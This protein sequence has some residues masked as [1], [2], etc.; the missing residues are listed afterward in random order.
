MNWSG[1]VTAGGNISSTDEE[2][3]LGQVKISSL[4][5]SGTSDMFQFTSPT[6][7]PYLDIGT[8]GA[9]NLNGGDGTN[10]DMHPVDM[11]VNLSG[12]TPIHMVVYI[13]N[14]QLAFFANRDNSGTPR[15]VAGVLQAQQ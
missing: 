15:I 9:V 8:G 7:T 3:L 14:P 12:I 4:S 5:L 11:D 1:L 10:G 2:D 13:V 6:L